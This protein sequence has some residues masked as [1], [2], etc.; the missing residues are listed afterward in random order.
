MVGLIRKKM[1]V[2]AELKR[3]LKENTQLKDQLE[4]RDC[5][6]VIQRQKFLSEKIN[7][8]KKILNMKIFWAKISVV[9]VFLVLAMAFTLGCPNRH[10]PKNCL[11]R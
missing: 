4:K 7:L 10:M 9:V 5:E 11:P 1:A 6:L 2:D 3:S 8:K